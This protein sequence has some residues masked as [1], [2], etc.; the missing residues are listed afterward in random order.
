VWIFYVIDGAFL[1]HLTGA[2]VIGGS[3]VAFVTWLS[4]LHGSGFG[5]FIAGLPS[6]AAFGFLFIGWNQSAVVAANATTQFPF[7]FSFIGVFLLSYAILALRTGFWKAL[8]YSTVIW[9]ILTALVA[10]SGLEIFAVS[11]VAAFVISCVVYLIFATKLTFVKQVPKKRGSILEITLRFFIGGGVVLLSVLTSQIAGPHIGVIPTSFPAISSSSL[12]VLNKGQGIEFSRAF[13][14]SIMLTSVMT[15]IPYSVGV[16][17]L[18][19]LIGI[20]WG[21]VGCYLIAIP[22]G[23]LAYLVIHG[24]LDGAKIWFKV[25]AAT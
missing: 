9:M 3:W 16:R 19:P 11:L 12:Y 21:T 22:F 8:I 20:W 23:L 17:V 2:F 14:K 4:E 15:V 6:T 25:P 18:Y 13:A 7:I 1:L 10:V 5:G 24:K